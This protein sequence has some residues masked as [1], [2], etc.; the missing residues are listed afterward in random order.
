[1]ARIQYH[2][3][4]TMGGYIQYLATGES[5]P[6]DI[7]AN[8]VFKPGS[9]ILLREGGYEYPGDR[10]H[11]EVSVN[12]H[13]MPGEQLQLFNTEPSRIEEAFADSR[14]RTATPTVIGLAIN[15]AK[16]IGTGLTYSDSLSEHS[17]KLAKKGME[18]G[19]VTANQKNVEAEKTNDIAEEGL[20]GYPHVLSEYSISKYDPVSDEE[21]G[22]ARKTIRDLVRSGRPAKH[23]GPQ[24]KH[25]DLDTEW[26]QPE[27]DK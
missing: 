27:L 8:A 2:K 14:M 23:M 13:K 4:P 12:R 6:Q 5:E 10:F 17:S 1:M 11:D 9:T 19:A 26:H 3:K 18:L 25:P 16:E 15:R 21:V 7:G 24:F 20:G 22:A